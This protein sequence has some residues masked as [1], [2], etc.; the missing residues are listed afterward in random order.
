MEKTRTIGKMVVALMILTVGVVSTSIAEE[1]DGADWGKPELLTP[2]QQRM[3][4]EISIDFRDTPIDDVL[5]IMAKQADVDIILCGQTAQLNHHITI[6]LTCRN[7]RL[8]RQ[9]QQWTGF[10]GHIV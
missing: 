3:Q 10:F 5:M 1:G 2:V 6:K 8:V 4:Q 9:F 7:D